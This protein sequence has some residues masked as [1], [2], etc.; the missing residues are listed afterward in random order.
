MAQ[1]NR[2]YYPTDSL[3]QEQTEF[4]NEY[5][6]YQYPNNDTNHYHDE[7]LWFLIFDTVLQSW[8]VFPHPDSEQVVEKSVYVNYSS[9]NI[10]GTMGS[11]GS[12]RVLTIYLKDRNFT[13]AF[14]CFL[15]ELNLWC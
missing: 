5:P 8:S 13:E 14:S 11:R 15:I 2:G 10:N 4:Y 7:G 9:V 6:S 1:D 12:V 3:N